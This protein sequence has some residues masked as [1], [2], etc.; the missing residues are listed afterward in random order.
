M[1]VGISDTLKNTIN[2]YVV[3]KVPTETPPQTPPRGPNHATLPEIREEQLTQIRPTALDTALEQSQHNES[4]D[5]SHDQLK[6]SQLDTTKK[7]RK[8]TALK[9]LK[10]LPDIE[11][12]YRA[13]AL[14][15]QNRILEAARQAQETRPQTKPPQAII[16]R[17]PPAPQSSSNPRKRAVVHPATD[18]TWVEAICFCAHRIG[19]RFTPSQ[20]RDFMSKHMKEYIA[21]R[22]SWRS[23]VSSVLLTNTDKYW[24]RTD[25][26]HTNERVYEIFAQARIPRQ[27]HLDALEAKYHRYKATLEPRRHSPHQSRVHDAESDSSQLTELSESQ[28]GTP[29]FMKTRKKIAVSAQPIT[30][31]VVK[32]G[33]ASIPKPKVQTDMGQSPVVPFKKGL[34]Q[35]PV[36][37]PRKLSHP[38]RLIKKDTPRKSAST[39]TALY[40]TP[41]DEPTASV[42]SHLASVES[43][44]PPNIAQ[45][46]PRLLND[47]PTAIPH[48]G[49]ANMIS[50]T[51]TQGSSS[52]ILT[53]V[54]SLPASTNLQLAESSI[55]AHVSFNDET[56]IDLTTDTDAEDAN[57]NAMT[58]DTPLEAPGRTLD[59]SSG[60]NNISHGLE[61]RTSRDLRDFILK[62]ISKEQREAPW[63]CKDLFVQN[64]SLKPGQ[65]QRP[66]N[67]LHVK[68]KERW[69]QAAHRGFVSGWA[70]VKGGLV[71][72][73]PQMAPE[74]G[75]QTGTTNADDT[76]DSIIRA[77][78]VP[79]DLDDSSFFIPYTR[80]PKKAETLDEAFALPKGLALELDSATR[81]LVFRDATELVSLRVLHLLSR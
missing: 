21:A 13:S 26:A 62:A 35:P 57:T 31:S 52:D 36:S 11:T 8:R 40:N 73:Y 68:R 46:V 61:H 60:S 17:T 47:A 27:L 38:T 39:T 23:S 71:N 33:Q 67:I 42:A 45:S 69:R 51:S 6:S 81:E 18:L 32:P 24:A 5:V 49:P 63:T 10:M 44:D 59:Q 22:G 29:A 65:H 19:R 12:Y 75:Q 3:A 76:D 70:D 25:N 72:E 28:M 53:N 37:S 77:G 79:M 1:D 64:P 66:N 14:S 74:L 34:S 50:M 48:P 41:E 9:L 2:G 15:P 43:T 16:I 30:S 7:K 55:A 80:P 58:L 56:V 78:D 20:V 4:A 54:S